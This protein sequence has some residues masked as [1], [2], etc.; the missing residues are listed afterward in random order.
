MPTADADVRIQSAQ[1]AQPSETA[2]AD[3]ESPNFSK[4][5]V[6]QQDSQPVMA[7]SPAKSTAYQPSRFAAE[8]VQEADISNG[9]TRSESSQFD[10]TRQ[11]LK[12]EELSG[13]GG[14]GPSDTPWLAREAEQAGAPA[15]QGVVTQQSSDS[16]SR[17]GG[18]F[19]NRAG[20]L[21]D[22]PHGP[23]QGFSEQPQDARSTFTSDSAPVLSGV[24]QVL[25]PLHF[26]I[27]VIL[28]PIEC[29]DSGFPCHTSSGCTQSKVL[30]AELTALPMLI[31]LLRLGWMIESVLPVSSNLSTEVSTLVALSMLPRVPCLA[32]AQVSC[33]S[34]H[35]A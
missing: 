27:P 9:D 26:V 19:D 5:S 17:Q 14:R 6:P 2:A 18:G 10:G 28:A 33:C 25:T 8:A 12:E 4:S 3:S 24:K 23:G 30:W 31:L 16:D 32:N 35:L 34:P 21:S 20:R 15:Q 22:Q 1:S 13:T 7:Q 29:Y 11:G